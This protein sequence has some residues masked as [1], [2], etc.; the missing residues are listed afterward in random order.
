MILIRS[1]GPHP[2]SCF[3]SS[4]LSETKPHLHPNRR[5][6]S[7]GFLITGEKKHSS[8]FPKSHFWFIF[9]ELHLTQLSHQRYSTACANSPLGWA[10]ASKPKGVLHTALQEA[11]LS[12]C[13]RQVR[14][15]KSQDEAK[16]TARSVCLLFCFMRWYYCLEI[17]HLLIE[18]QRKFNR[19]M[20]FWNL[21]FYQK[22]KVLQNWAV[23]AIISFW[24][25]KKKG[26]FSD[27]VQI[28]HSYIFGMKTSDSSLE[29]T[30]PFL[31]SDS[32]N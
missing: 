17:H 22:W 25:T 10:A 1:I 7:W 28:S 8:R 13:L 26:N 2:T 21:R 12:C 29:K 32:K 31:N 23:F 3:S 20:F 5:T 27:D 30:S 24:G 18:G 11:S 14:K 16:V 6:S 4:V 15:G 19:I 9:S